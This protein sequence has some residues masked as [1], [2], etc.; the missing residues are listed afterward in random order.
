M[1]VMVSL[2]LV[3]VCVFAFMTFLCAAIYLG[4]RGQAAVAWL[5]GLLNR[6]A[7]DEIAWADR[8][9]R[10][11]VIFCDIDQFKQINDRY[12]HAAGDE[13]IRSFA[14]LLASTGQ[15]AAHDLP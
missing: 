12:G 3:H 14:S 2:S 10:G 13:V 9:G 11:A 4:M 5:A 6:Q 1:S 8:A 15:H 7:F